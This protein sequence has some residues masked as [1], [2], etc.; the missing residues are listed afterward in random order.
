MIID[1]HVHESMHSP[2]SEMTLGEAVA[3][4]RFHGLDGICI[5]DHDSMEIQNDAADYLRTVDFPV[6][7]GVELSTTVG[8][9]IALGLH[10]LPKSAHYFT[11]VSAQDFINYVNA[12]GGFCFAAHPCRGSNGIFLNFVKGLHGIEQG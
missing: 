1:M 10:S 4:A 8:H 6:F 5:T 2:C 7:I 12:Q 11:T 9:I 3:A